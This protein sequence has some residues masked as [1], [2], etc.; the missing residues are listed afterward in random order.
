MVINAMGS[1]GILSLGACYERSHTLC[2][3]ALNSRAKRFMR[4]E[5]RSSFWLRQS[6]NSRRSSSI[7]SLARFTSTSGVFPGT[8]GT[9]VFCLASAFPLLKNGAAS[10]AGAPAYHALFYE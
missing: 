9:V 10:L 2:P 4:S 3:N 8:S 5:R 1:F 6:R 7:L